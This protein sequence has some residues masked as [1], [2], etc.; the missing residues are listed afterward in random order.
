MDGL[1]REVMRSRREKGGEEE[2]PQPS[3]RQPSESGGFKASE[4]HC[5]R[6]S[7]VG[8]R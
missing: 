4:D 3:Q 5:C 2:I 8:V 7:V 1:L 6:G